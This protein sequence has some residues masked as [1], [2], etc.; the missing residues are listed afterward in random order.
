MN[1]IFFVVLMSA[2]LALFTG[3]SHAAPAPGT[4]AIYGDVPH[5]G[6]YPLTKTTTLLDAILRSGGMRARPASVNI[7][8]ARAQGTL[9]TINGAQLLSNP[10]DAPALLAGDI[11]FVPQTIASPPI[12]NPKTA[13]AQSR[14]GFRFNGMTIYLVP[15]KRVRQEIVKNWGH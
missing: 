10:Q 15:L 7:Q 2:C 1:R 4:I 5:P 6:I 8:I 9:V 12:A 14:R 13:P 11:V 3:L